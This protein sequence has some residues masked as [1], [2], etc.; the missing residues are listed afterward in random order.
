MKPHHI[1]YLVT[2]IHAGIVQ[3][4][5]LEY[6]LSS[7]VFDIPDQKVKVC[8]LKNRN[9]DLFVELVEPYDS[10]GPLN[11]LLKKK[12]VSYYHLGVKVPDF[13][14]EMERLRIKGWRLVTEFFSKA[15]GG[16]KCAFFMMDDL[17]LIELIQE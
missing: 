5:F 15:F 2:D 17:A 8:F 11:R 14:V 16:K 4:Q 10:N 7:E 6:T 13:E 12:A 9:S 1:G 3:W